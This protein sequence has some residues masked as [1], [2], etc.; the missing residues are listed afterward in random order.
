MSFW[1]DLVGTSEQEAWSELARQVGGA[2]TART[3]RAP[4][5]VVARI[6][7]FDLVLDTY[8]V[9]T[10][11]SSTTFTR[12]R[13]P[14]ING[15]GLRFGVHRAHFLSPLEKF[16]GRQDLEIGVPDFD[17]SYVI[18][19][20]DEARVR[21]LLADPTLRALIAAHPRIAIEVVDNEGVF[22]APY[23]PNID[24][25][26]FLE[27]GV[28]R[29]VARLRGLF[30][31]FGALLHALRNLTPDRPPPT[32]SEMPE[33]FLRMLDD[34]FDS[35]GGVTERVGDTIEAR[36]ED[37]LGVA[38]PARA[39]LPLP[40]LPSLT[41]S[42]RFE[43][44]VPTSNDDLLIEKRGFFGGGGDKTGDV[45]VDERLTLRGERATLDRL[46]PSLAQLAAVHPRIEAKADQLTVQVEAF[47][48][49]AAPRVV[50]ATLDVW[51]E[52]CRARAGL[53]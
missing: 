3:W 42:L 8:T 7:G 38:G 10:G 52:L 17:R 11:K 19:G 47:D 45:A 25:L 37:P 13:A 35:L 31:L 41:S 21:S 16:F 39:L 32:P 6:G 34:V 36:L 22:G 12:L 49:A 44:G 29:D 4:S 53:E 5:S 50:G 43:A 48:A 2:F 9:S 28:I 27:H 40:R 24:L 51:Q 15:T 33:V 46:R 20:N 1:K 26:R 23:G 30:S 18:A 14:F